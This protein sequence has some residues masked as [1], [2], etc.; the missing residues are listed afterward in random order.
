[1]AHGVLGPDAAAGIN[2]QAR[3]DEVIGG[4]GKRVGVLGELAKEAVDLAL[5]RG[6]AVGEGIRQSGVKALVAAG[7]IEGKDAQSPNVDAGILV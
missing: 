1:M 5:V 2:A 7:K 6:R 4:L 3:L